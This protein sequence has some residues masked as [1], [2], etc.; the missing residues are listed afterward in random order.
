MNL[1]TITIAASVVVLVLPAAAFAAGSRAPV[2]NPDVYATGGQVTGDAAGL[3]TRIRKVERRVAALRVQI[4]TARTG[5]AGLRGELR[6]TQRLVSIL[7]AD[8]DAAIAAATPKTGDG[9][10][11]PNP[12][13][14]DY[15]ESSMVGCTPEQL[16]AVWGADCWLVEHAATVDGEPAAEQASA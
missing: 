13:P 6:A 1:R 7:R 12:A 14:G 8:L 4:Q 9:V 2:E 16:C 5:S 15:C 11:R 10:S 3:R